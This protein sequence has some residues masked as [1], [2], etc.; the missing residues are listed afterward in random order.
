VTAI[1]AQV[2]PNALSAPLN[3]FAALFSSGVR[4]LL[5]NE[6]FVHAIGVLL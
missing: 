4:M 1:I 3:L 2:R 5:I 6:K